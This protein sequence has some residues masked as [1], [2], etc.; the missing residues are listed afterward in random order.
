MLLKREKKKQEDKRKKL[1]LRMSKKQLSFG[2]KML[3]I[4]FVLRK[5]VNVV[6][7]NVVVVSNVNQFSRVIVQR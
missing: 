6:H 5:I 7:S 2:V 3:Y 1:H 4:V